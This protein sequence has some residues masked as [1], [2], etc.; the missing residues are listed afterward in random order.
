MKLDEFLWWTLLNQLALL[1]DSCEA[2]LADA[3][4][5]TVGTISSHASRAGCLYNFIG[6]T[7]DNR[8][9]DLV[10]QSESRSTNANLF[11]ISSTIA[12]AAFTV[13]TL[14]LS[15][16]IFI[17]FADLLALA[18]DERVAGLTDANLFAVPLTIVASLIVI[19]VVLAVVALDR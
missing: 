10:D 19:I 15:D 17:T 6:G 12:A 7:R 1:V 5:F 13:G 14:H 18:I 11:T 2:C 16:F 4:L 9:T 8:L 3:D